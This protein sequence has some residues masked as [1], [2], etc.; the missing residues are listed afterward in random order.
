MKTRRRPT[1]LAATPLHLLEMHQAT[2]QLR[3]RWANGVDCRG[4]VLRATKKRFSYLRP[5][6]A[7]LMPSVTGHDHRFTTEHIIAILTKELGRFFQPRPGDEERFHGRLEYFAECVVH[8]DLLYQLSHAYWDIRFTDPASGR[9]HGFPYRCSHETPPRRDDVMRVHHSFCLELDAYLGYP[10]KF[11]IRPYLCYYKKEARLG[12]FDDQKPV[13]AK[14][15]LVVVQDFE[16]D[17]DG[18]PVNWP[19]K[20]S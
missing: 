11:V 5:L 10:V 2:E 17:S 4:D 7:S 14:P 15:M 12:P 20:K 9:A 13:Q 6:T 18:W 8:F 1:E 16:R 3:I 19:I